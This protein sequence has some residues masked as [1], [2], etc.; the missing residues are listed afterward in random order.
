MGEVTDPVGVELRGQLATT[1]AEQHP[2]PERLVL[3][4]AAE[5]GTD[6]YPADQFMQK[7]QGVDEGYP[8]EAD[9][10]YYVVFS[11]QVDNNADLSGA[12]ICDSIS[13]EEKAPCIPLD[14][15]QPAKA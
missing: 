7:G 1:A 6:F 10:P 15:P 3:I 11:G 13:E 5:P 12:E 14:K 2:A 9:T 4:P 8:L